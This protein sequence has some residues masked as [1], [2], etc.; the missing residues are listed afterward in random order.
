MAGSTHT[1]PSSRPNSCASWPGWVTTWPSRRS[2]RY[3]DGGPRL[4]PSQRDD[5]VTKGINPQLRKV[6]GKTL[7]QLAAD[8][9]AN[10]YTVWKSYDEK[11]GIRDQMYAIAAANPQLAKLVKLGTTI[12]GREILAIKLTQGARGADGAGRRCSTAPPST[13][14]SGSPPRSTVD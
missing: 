6:K 14:E 12:Q 10:G 7:K 5:L 3:G 4:S 13:P 11:G 9:A 8:D 1:P 2:P